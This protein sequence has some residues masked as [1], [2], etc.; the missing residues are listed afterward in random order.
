MPWAFHDMECNDTAQCQLRR[1]KSQLRGLRVEQTCVLDSSLFDFK[2][3]AISS[4]PG[5]LFPLGGQYQI[6]Q[7]VSHQIEQ[8]LDVFADGTGI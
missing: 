8:Q 6:P 4:R 7:L 1:R 5:A 3:A 2:V